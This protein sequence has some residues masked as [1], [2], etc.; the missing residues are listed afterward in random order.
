MHP[1]KLLICLV[2]RVLKCPFSWIDFVVCATVDVYVE[3]ILK[4][5]TTWEKMRPELTSFF[6][7]FIVPSLSQ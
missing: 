6:F 4:D 3:R 1:E 5:E 2:L 7:S